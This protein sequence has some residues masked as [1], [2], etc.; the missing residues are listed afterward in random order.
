MTIKTPTTICL[1]LLTSIAF[2]GTPALEGI[3]NDVNG[4]PIK[5]ADVKVEAR[6]GT[7]SKTLKTDTNGHYLVS[8][9]ALG[10]PYKV[11]LVVNG[12]VKASILNANARDGKPATLNFDLKIMKGPVTRRMIYIAPDTGTH[13]GGGRW[14]TVDENGN[15]VN[16]DANVLKMNPNAGRA[17]DVRTGMGP[18]N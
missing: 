7:F 17:M 11:T 16:D 2:A 10:T 12:T 5:G 9:L 3:V 4:R 13:I 18:G 8:G 14:V 1:M 6:T 15:V